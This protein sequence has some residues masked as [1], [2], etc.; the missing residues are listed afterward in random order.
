M[1]IVMRD[2]KDVWRHRGRPPTPIPEI[3]QRLADES[4]RT[5]QCA[6]A[7]IGPEDTE[8]EVKELVRLF[9]IY[10]KRM[11]RRSRWQQNE[12]VLVLTMYDAKKYVP[13]KKVSA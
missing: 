10:A 5:G 13:R 12:N 3:I 4:Y 11:G 6:T 7:I 1:E 9:R 2:P 8:E